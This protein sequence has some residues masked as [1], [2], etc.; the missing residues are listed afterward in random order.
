VEYFFSFLFPFFLRGP[1]GGGR[2][3]LE[4]EGLLNTRIK[5]RQF[6]ES[7]KGGELKAS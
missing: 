4:I 5:R 6:L 7:K 3:R 2:G 1:V